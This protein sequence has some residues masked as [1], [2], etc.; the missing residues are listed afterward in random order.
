M[1]IRF[2]IRPPPGN[3]CA[4]GS[5]CN[6]RMI[7]RQHCQILSWHGGVGLRPAIS[8][9]VPR[10]LALTSGLKDVG[11]NADIAGQRPTPPSARRARE[12]GDWFHIYCELVRPMHK[13]VF[14][15]FL[16]AIR[17]TAAEPGR[18]RPWPVL[19]Q[20]CWTCHGREDAMSGLRLDSRAARAEGV[21]RHGAAVTPGKL[22]ESRLWLAV[23]GA[24]SPFD[25][26]GREAARR[27]LSRPSASGS[28]QGR[29]GRRLRPRP[30]G[31]SRSPSR[32]VYPREWRI[33]STRSFARSWS[34]RDS[35]PRRRRIGS[36]C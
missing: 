36:L 32:G 1:R 21:E 16:I 7:T 15:G 34:R 20:R 14:L 11:T 24:V 2:C 26:A 17:L 8:P 23:T 19:Q 10:F 31:H 13:V 3:P 12:Q 27:G 35:N 25:A 9:F 6:T 18:S 5:I 28:A 33:R 30:G 29:L 4:E 22:D